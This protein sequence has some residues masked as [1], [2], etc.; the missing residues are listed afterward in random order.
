[1]KKF[2]C[3]DIIT[4]VVHGSLNIIQAK[5]TTIKCYRF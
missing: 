2:E 3:L 5:E 1:M 4:Y